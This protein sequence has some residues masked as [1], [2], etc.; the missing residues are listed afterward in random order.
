MAEK[1]I[2]E[3]HLTSYND[4]FADIVNGCIAIL[5]GKH[6]FCGVNPDDL[7]DTQTR[8]LY[9]SGDEVREQER[10]VA[11]LW[12]TGKTV[13]CLMGLENQTDVDP[14][15]P[16]RVFGYEGGD[17]RWQLAQRDKNKEMKLYPVLT[18]VLYFGTE[19]R[20]TRN[21]TLSERLGLVDPALC[22][23]LNDCRLHVLEIAWLTDEE[24]SV[25][26]SDFRVVVDFLRQIRQDKTFV[27]SDQMIVHV[28][29]VLKL[30]A[31]LT[32]ERGL[33]NLPGIKKGGTPMTVRNVFGEAR[34]EGIRIGEA[35]GIQ[36]GETRGI[37]IGKTQGFLDA[38]FSC[39]GDGLLSIAAAARKANMSEDEF[40]V[41]MRKQERPNEA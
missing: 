24:A 2:V 17:Y 28:D 11:K 4:V 26:A 7:Q 32:G 16:L 8:T 29:A 33:E 22:H 15:M 1:D 18:F 27:P 21:R 31:V 5:G 41:L 19:R 25:F 6:P 39:V 40:R 30:L 14:D 38:L 9:T 37:Q 12:K 13:L 34:E 10:D 36:I 3:C 23:F 35:R 20:W